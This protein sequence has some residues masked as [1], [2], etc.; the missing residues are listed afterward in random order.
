MLEQRLYFGLTIAQPTIQQLLS[1]S[2]SAR[3]E[4]NQTFQK[5]PFI[6]TMT[7]PG[8]IAGQPGAGQLEAVPGEIGE[9]SL[10]PGRAKSRR[11]SGTT[12]L[13]QLLL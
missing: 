6:L 3:H 11:P 10:A 2:F 7:T 4:F 8:C 9:G 1:Q 12:T 13:P 5:D